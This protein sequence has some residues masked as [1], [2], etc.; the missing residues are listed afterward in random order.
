MKAKGHQS[1]KQQQQKKIPLYTNKIF[2]FFFILDV[3]QGSGRKY[4]K[5][6]EIYSRDFYLP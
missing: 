6:S 2:Y 4:M 1:T 3:V 5:Q